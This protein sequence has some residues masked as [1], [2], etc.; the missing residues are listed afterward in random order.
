MIACDL[1]VFL[2]LYPFKESRHELK[3]QILPFKHPFEQEN[4]V[5]LRILTRQLKTIR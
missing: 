4:N 5:S 3:N 2:D 1:R